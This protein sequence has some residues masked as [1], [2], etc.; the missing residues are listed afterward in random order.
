M[1][2]IF[3]LIMAVLLFGALSFAAQTD[4]SST[5]T[6]TTKT[7]TKTKKAKADKTKVAKGKIVSASDTEVVLSH[8]VKG[9]EQNETFAINSSTQKSGDLNAGNWATVHYTAEGG[10]NT[11]TMVS[12]K[13]PKAGKMSKK[14]DKDAGAAPQSK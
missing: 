8:K 12:A 11:A 3:T 2:K 13:A 7:T 10:T 5:S 6:T 14:K 1:K 9:Q 4:Q